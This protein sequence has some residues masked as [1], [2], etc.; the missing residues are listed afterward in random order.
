[1]G[2]FG[3]WETND[4]GWRLREFAKSHRLILANTLHP[5]KLSMSMTATWHAPYGQV[6]PDRLYPD[7]PTLQVQHQQSNHKVFPGADTGSDH[8]IKLMLKTKRFMKSS[9]I[10]FDLEKLKDPKIVE[11]YHA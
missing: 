4:R 6:R 1:M 3:I 5:H 11:V 9:R 10:Q 2:S 7:N 8:G